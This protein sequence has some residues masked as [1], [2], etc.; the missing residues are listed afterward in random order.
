MKSPDNSATAI[1]WGMLEPHFSL[2]L[3]M[4]MLQQASG[5]CVAVV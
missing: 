4:Q 1:A 2:Q 3:Q 5:G